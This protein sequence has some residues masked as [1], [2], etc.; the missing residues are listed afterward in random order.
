[1]TAIFRREYAAYFRRPVGTVFIVLFVLLC[2]AAGFLPQEFFA[3]NL[4]TLHV[5]NRW[6]PWILIVFVPAVTMGLWAEERQHG[7]DE[8]LLTLPLTD[9]QIVLGKYLAALAIYLT[10]LAF[11]L[12]F[13]FVLEYLGEPDYGL[14]L[15][16]YLGYALLGAMLIAVAMV[17]SLLSTNMTVS[18]LLGA[19]FTAAMVFSDQAA[20]AA[21]DVLERSFPSVAMRASPDRYF[22][23]APFRELA[24]GALSLQA[25]V[26][27]VAT[28]AAGISLSLLILDQRRRGVAPWRRIGLPIVHA[29]AL[30]AGVVSLSALAGRVPLR[31]DL[32][33][34]GE[35]SL[36]PATREVLRAL[37]P[38]Q[39]V[40]IRAFV[41]PQMPSEYAAARANLLRWLREYEVLSGGAIIAEVIP[42]KEF[43]EEAQTGQETYGIQPQQVETQ[44]RGTY[45]RR[46][47]FFGLVFSCGPRQTVIPFLHPGLPMEYELTRSIRFVAKA[48]RRRVGFLNTPAR[49][50]G[51]FDF[52][53]MSMT[54]AW[55]VVEELRKQYE[56]VE[57]ARDK[58]YP[59]DLDVLVAVLPSA[60]KQEDMD[61]LFNY[62]K[63]GKPV[64]IVDDPLPF[65]N[66]SLAAANPVVSRAS[67]P[68][69]GGPPPESK[70]NIRS[71]FES[72]G[73]EW[74]PAQVVWDLYNP[75]PKYGELII[76]EYVCVAAESGSSQAFAADHPITRGFHEVILLAPG[77]L[78]KKP[79][80]KIEFIP[81]LR[82]SPD[83]GLIAHD[84]VIQTNPFG[85]GGGLNP[86]RRHRRTPDE[87]VLAA[88]VRGESLRAVVLLDSD[89]ISN[90]FF[91]LRRRGGEEFRLDNVSFVLNAID[92][93]SGD[94]A[95]VALRTRRTR[96]RTLARIEEARREFERERDDRIREAEDA[97]KERLDEAQKRFDDAIRQVEDRQDL[98]QTA[99]EILI[100]QRRAVEQRR[101]DVQRANIEAEKS[102]KIQQA[103]Q[104]LNRRIA[105]ME[106]AVRVG[107]ILLPPLPPII[108]AC[109]MIVLRLAAR[110]GR[111]V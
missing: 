41:S 76:P 17:A 35:L 99:K 40:R 74:D 57:V 107:A 109:I 87:Y 89:V 9:A 102:R 23:I 29:L 103:R 91:D 31:A 53:R 44:E 36:S 108:L 54:S 34:G 80:A 32:T 25:V 3:S 85:M 70:G 69:M 5:L 47:I 56:V 95:F 100:A 86:A 19:L 45:E 52:Q 15:A 26:L 83:S 49:I 12:A 14:L 18:F 82:T 2:G 68:F 1:M 96:P 79:D 33:A 88:E 66:P 20:R 10:G 77:A 38:R 46:T 13:V 50:F 7:T 97:A 111:V 39:P 16:N 64:L 106:T 55:D 81:L 92:L 62:V 93:L 21:Q 90:V 58:D 6:F 60:L 78:R 51:G 75:H 73:L 22:P 24:E 42:T 94:E 59:N 28:A 4:C 84:E 110:A 105:R 8:L 101:L 71:A 63:T 67:N 65:W 104:E 72:L 27:L 48:E 37:D 61:R 30:G 11:A 43:S 98:D